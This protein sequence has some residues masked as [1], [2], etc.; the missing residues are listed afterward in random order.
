MARTFG[1]VEIVLGESLALEQRWPDRLLEP[2]RY[3]PCGRRVAALVVDPEELTHLI[4][5]LAGAIAELDADARGSAAGTR[6]PGP[7]IVPVP[8]AKGGS[9]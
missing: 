1:A 5:V 7:Q 4:D 9:A 8:S 3:A 6:T 2:V